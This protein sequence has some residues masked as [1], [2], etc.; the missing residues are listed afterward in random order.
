MNVH[1]GYVPT[2]Q[3]T[4]GAPYGRWMVGSAM[5][6]AP[7]QMTLYSCRGS[8]GFLRCI[9]PLHGPCVGT[10]SP[11]EALQLYSLLQ[12]STALQ[13]YSST[14]ACPSTQTFVTSYHNFPFFLLLIN[15]TNFAKV[16]RHFLKKGVQ[17]RPADQFEFK[18]RK[19][20][21]RHYTYGSSRDSAS[22]S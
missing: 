3:V 7:R 21:S 18:T 19:Q 10:H 20:A 15:Y 11:A 14:L 17:S 1:W 22:D 4:K 2:Q 16:L 13:L 6:T 12:P 9:T 8:T 5:A